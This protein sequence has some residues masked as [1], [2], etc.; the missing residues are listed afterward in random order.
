[1]AVEL[2]GF[3]VG[4]GFFLG[5]ALALLTHERWKLIAEAYGRERHRH[6]SRNALI[7]PSR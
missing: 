2:V 7:W 1:M 5:A 6:R 3:A 4:V